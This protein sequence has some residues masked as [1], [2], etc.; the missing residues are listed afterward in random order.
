MKKTQEQM[1]KKWQTLQ[2]QEKDQ[3]TEETDKCPP[4]PKNNKDSSG[5]LGRAQKEMENPSPEVAK[6][7]ASMSCPT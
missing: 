3:T 4:S 1:Q 7:A 2:V 5:W 6:V